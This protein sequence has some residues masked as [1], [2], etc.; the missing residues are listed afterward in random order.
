MRE[1]ETHR[2]RERLRV[3][4]RAR[5]ETG[6]VTA[7]HIAIVYQGLGDMDEAMRWF[8]LAYAERATDCC[9]Y[10][11]ATQFDVAREDPRFRELIASI[12]AGGAGETA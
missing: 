9:S 6:Y 3:S 2:V 12:E 7:T 4:S 8:R 5:R 10:G 11:I 1:R